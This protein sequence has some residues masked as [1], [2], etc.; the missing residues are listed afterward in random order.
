MTEYEH[1]EG[2]P[3]SVTFFELD[4]YRMGDS[5]EFDQWYVKAESIERWARSQ[6]KTRG[7]EDKLEVYDYLIQETA[8]KLGLS[9]HTN[10]LMLLDSIYNHTQKDVKPD[11]RAK[12]RRVR[13]KLSNEH[14]Q[15]KQRLK[16]R[17]TNEQKKTEEALSL[18]LKD[19][20]KL[21]REKNDGL[22]SRRKP[23]SKKS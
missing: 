13:E 4:G 16:T 12:I 22:R 5:K 11:T 18:A 19:I 14:E 21:K 9:Q 20:R 7:L 1:Y 2:S 6:I 10:K 8:D 3:Y 15:S 23:G 17:L